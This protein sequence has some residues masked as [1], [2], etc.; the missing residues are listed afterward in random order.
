MR[1]VR[2]YKM[3]RGDLGASLE[4]SLN[5]GIIVLLI[6]IILY[7][8]IWSIDYVLIALLIIV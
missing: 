6:L 3:R 2:K 8:Y 1:H 5:D 4:K 7:M